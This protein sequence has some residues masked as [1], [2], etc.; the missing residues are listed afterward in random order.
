MFSIRKETRKDRLEVERLIYRVLNKNNDNKCYEHY[1]VCRLRGTKDFY[2]DFTFVAEEKGEIVGFITLSKAIIKDGDTEVETLFL[3]PLV[4]HDEYQRRGIGKT[5]LKAALD[6]AKFLGHQHVFAYGCKEYLSLHGFTSTGHLEITNK[7]GKKEKDMLVITFKRDSLKDI[8]GKL[9]ISPTLIEVDEN[10]F[11]L[12][13]HALYQVKEKKEKGIK[14]AKKIALIASIIFSLV[15]ATFLILSS[16]NIVSSEVGLGTVV[17]AIAGCLGSI[18][19]S[20]FNDQNKVMGWIS[21][22]LSLIIFAL[23]FMMILG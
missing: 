17:F 23:G 20:H 9:L 10:E 18:S 1:K 4:V 16:N 14:N 21:L 11:N 8:K 15:A 5:L 12:Y 19:F 13:H 22:I 2:K 7:E 6:E 3:H